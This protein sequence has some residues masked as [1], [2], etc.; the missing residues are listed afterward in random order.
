MMISFRKKEDDRVAF[1]D[2]AGDLAKDRVDVCGDLKAEWQLLKP[3]SGVGG[4][5]SRDFVLDD[6]Y[7]VPEGATSSVTAT[8]W[9][10]I[11]CTLV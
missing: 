2:L 10:A 5:P 8:G 1:G 4:G 11:I 9:G 6:K 3:N 7:K